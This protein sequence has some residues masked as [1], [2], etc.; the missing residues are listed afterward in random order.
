[1]GTLVSAPAP[2]S[3]G[4]RVSQIV[5]M[6]VLGVGVLV[7]LIV[8]LL[9]IGKE[10]RVSLSRLAFHSGGISSVYGSAIQP[11]F[12]MHRGDT[13]CHANNS[14]IYLFIHSFSH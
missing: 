14:I 8:V 3:S 9:V 7:A 11:T 4:I 1:M 13:S 2:G 5:T 12:L 10:R 6:I